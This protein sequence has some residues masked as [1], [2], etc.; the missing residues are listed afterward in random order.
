[1]AAILCCEARFWHQ[2]DI[3]R[4]AASG[5]ST[6][7]SLWALGPIC[8]SSYSLSSA[9]NEILG[10][11]GPR[12]ERS[13]PQEAF[14]FNITFVPIR[15][16]RSKPLRVNN[17]VAYPSRLDCMLPDCHSHWR[18][19]ISNKLADLGVIASRR[20]LAAGRATQNLSNIRPL[21]RTHFI[22][23]ALAFSRE[24]SLTHHTAMREKGL[25]SAPKR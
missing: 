22:I 17:H 5:A 25:F 8:L 4:S 15:M 19:F 3:L 9:A 1:M 24:R 21:F 11:D 18:P 23:P 12:F 13:C 6:E 16:H 10:L 20:V 7:A 2:L 14:L